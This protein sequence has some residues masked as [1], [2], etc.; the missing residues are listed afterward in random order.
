MLVTSSY[1]PDK[2][3]HEDCADVTNE[4][5]GTGYSGGGEELTWT[6]EIAFPSGQS[7]AV[8]QDNIND[9]AEFDADDVIWGSS[10]ITA[11]A[12]ILYKDSGTP[13]TSPLIAYIDF[14]NDF[15]ASDEDFTI[16]WD[17]EGILYLGE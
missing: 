13:S 12:A 10:T 11:R 7:D 17:G 2:D 4:V 5:T 3:A 1:S 15:S 6:D 14:G 8:S 9:R 16:E